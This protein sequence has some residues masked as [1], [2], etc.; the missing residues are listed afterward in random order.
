[1]WEESYYLFD[2]SVGFRDFGGIGFFESEYVNVSKLVGLFDFYLGVGWGYLG[3]VDDIINLFCE[4]K[5]SFCEC[6]GGFLGC[7]G[8]VDYD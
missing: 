7:G 8:K 4:V 1:M 5:D 3:I 6:F 2:I